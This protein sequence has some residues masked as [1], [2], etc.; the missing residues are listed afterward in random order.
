VKSLLLRKWLLALPWCLLA[1]PI[2]E[3]AHG[4][5]PL[6]KV[7]ESQARL[8]CRDERS[9]SILASW[10]AALPPESRALIQD[11]IVREAATVGVA[12]R[13]T[14]RL[15]EAGKRIYVAQAAKQGR[16]D[17]AA[18]MHRINELQ[19]EFMS[20]QFPMSLEQALRSDTLGSSLYIE[21]AAETIRPIADPRTQERRPSRTLP[22]RRNDLANEPTH[23]ACGDVFR[24][25][26]IGIDERMA[27]LPTEILRTGEPN[28]FT[29]QIE[30]GTDVVTF[31]TPG[32]GC[33]RNPPGNAFFARQPNGLL[34]GNYS[35]L[36]F[37]EVVQLSFSTPN[38]KRW[39]CSG[40][41]L[42]KN[43]AL[44]AAHC[45]DDDGAAAGQPVA[46]SVML[47]AKVSE[48][49]RAKGLPTQSAVVGS[50]IVH[51]SYTQA[52][53]QQLPEFKKGLSDI[54][55]LSL[56]TPLEVGAATEFDSAKAPEALLGTLAG[57][58]ATLARPAA[59]V[60]NAPLDVGWLRLSMTAAAVMWETETAPNTSANASC[61]GD[62]G[63]PIYMLLADK[64]P[65]SDEPAIGCIGEKRE[66][67]G[68]VSFGL[69]PDGRSCARG[70]SSGA[71]PRLHPHRAW[72]CE[73]SGLMCR[74]PS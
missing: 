66:L 25:Y 19:R 72:I 6:G 15:K 2:T 74:G 10:L 73:K 8:Q 51:E 59:D 9:A 27:F 18:A 58:G 48:L 46:V 26:L 28:P 4:F 36:G 16:V 68:L 69:S 24:S 56:A 62:S 32:T 31:K 7:A 35:S 57:Y 20:E 21:A 65:V 49:R 17:R 50:P 3:P 61:P 5:D 53:L 41:L 43:W 30:P 34:A 54:A 38:N 33:Q 47:N 13:Q 60:A 1:L 11:P 14:K 63:A 37:P 67:V 42:D 23:S 71:G 52:R 45:I 44:T 39:I 55:L 40:V 22:L 64:K 29:L 70:S 12:T